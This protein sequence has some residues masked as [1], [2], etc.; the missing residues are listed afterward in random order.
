VTIV[1]RGG[2]ALQP[3]GGLVLEAGDRLLV[4]GDAHDEPGPRDA[5][6]AD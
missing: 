1:L 2:S 3:H 6:A 4:I 5:T